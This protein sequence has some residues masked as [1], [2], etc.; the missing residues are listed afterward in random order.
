[1]R[2]VRGADAPAWLTLGWIIA[3]IVLLV[4]IVFM[5]ISQIDIRLGGLIAGLAL[6]RL[7]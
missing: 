4:D 6:A 5:A 1:M 3:L 2:V 7:L